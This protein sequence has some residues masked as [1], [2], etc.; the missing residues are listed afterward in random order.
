M[1]YLTSI[2]NT[3]YLEKMREKEGG[4]YG[5][6]VSGNIDKF[7]RERFIFQVYFDTNPAKKEKLMAIVYDEIGK[8]MQYGP[9]KEQL[10]K[11]AENLLKRY[12]EASTEKNS[13][14]WINK[15]WMLYVYGIDGRL[16]Y[17]KMVMSVTPE[18]ISEFA[19][20]LFRQGNLIEVVMDPMEEAAN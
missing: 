2:L 7:P 15:A 19:K 16:D 11:V 10:N 17:E 12:K 3:T 14:Y 9:S 5:A 6:G 4:T 18:M 20:R 1:E 13:E 8:I